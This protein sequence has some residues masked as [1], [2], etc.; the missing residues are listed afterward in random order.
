MTITARWAEID[1]FLAVRWDTVHLPSGASAA[2]LEQAE[3]QLGFALPPD[4]RV[5]LAIHDGSGRLWLSEYG[6]LLP[7]AGIVRNWDML[8]A[9]WWDEERDGPPDCGPTA[10]SICG[11]IRPHWWH[12]RWVPFVWNV[13]GDH[14]CVDLAPPDTGV[15][16]QVITWYHNTGPE[17]VVAAGYD[18]FL[19]R[20]AEALAAG[21]ELA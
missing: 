5:S 21:W 9:L 1:R 16:G 15:A 20:I 17:E 19:G 8:T 18:E 13:Q 10:V 4:L 6:P 12:R 2:E 11:P 14:L 7:V 3:R